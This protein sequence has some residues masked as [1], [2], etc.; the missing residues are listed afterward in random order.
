MDKEVEEAESLDSG[1]MPAAVIS[2]QVAFS[3]VP[4][5]GDNSMTNMGDESFLRKVEKEEAKEQ[6][7]YNPDERTDTAEEDDTDEEEADS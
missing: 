4:Q 3:E 7:N 5:S 1:G 2:D 6:K